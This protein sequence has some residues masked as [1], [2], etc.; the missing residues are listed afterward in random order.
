MTL[1]PNEIATGTELLS[2]QLEKLI[3]DNR[4]VSDFHEAFVYYCS[5]KYSLGSEATSVVTDGKGDVGID[6][7]SAR[8]R[9]Y[10]VGQCKI[11]DQRWL[12]ANPLKT[13]PFGSSVVADPKTALRYLLGE[14]KFN[15]NEKVRH[16]YALVESDRIQEDFSLTFFLIV[17]GRLD[18]RARDAFEEL[19]E[20]YSSRKNI[21][22][23]LQEIDDLVDEFL[24]GAS[25]KTEIQL[26]F[27]IDKSGILSA[28]NYCY[29][30]ANAAD[31]F[32]AFRNYGWRL[33]DLNLRYEIRN[34]PINNDIITTLKY[35]KS[36]KNFHHY[37]NGLTIITK[38]YK[39]RDNNSKIHLTNPQIVNGLQT[40]KSIYNAITLKEVSFEELEK[41]CLIQVKVVNISDTDFITRVVRATNNQNPMSQRN[42]KAN[43]REQ[44]TLRVSCAQL[45]PRWFF[46]VK[47]G[48]W[49]SLTQESGQFFK[50][51]VN[52]PPNEFCVDSNKRRPRLID[53]EDA[54]KAWLAFI[55]FA[56][57]AGER[58][59]HY[60]NNDK[61]Y[62][63][64]FGRRPSKSY[65]Q[66]FAIALDFSESRTQE[67]DDYQGNAEQYLLA[68]FLWQFTKHFIPS[69]QK[70]R[71]EAL[72]EGVNLGKITKSSGSITSSEKT[73]ED[74]LTDSFIYQTWRLMANMKELLVEA[75]AHVLCRKYGPLDG[76]VCRKLLDDFDAKAF[77]TT[78]EIKETV[79]NA[80]SSSYIDPQAVFGRIF[81]L[82]KHTAGQF[83]EDKRISLLSTSRI[84]LTLLRR[85]I[86][87]DFKR[88]IWE[89]NERRHL[90]KP[91]KPEGKTFLESLPKLDG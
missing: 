71:E 56:D 78:G 16:L 37:N 66:K 70:Y 39:S 81:G 83:W 29:F 88:K 11:P 55:G 47:E 1:E 4:E 27:R 59:T 25:N 17:Y 79:Q 85:E 75:A 32:L 12:E 86:A 35:Q 34:S 36:R 26:D 3:A 44:K 5:R 18:A 14:S 51:V 77:L 48:E 87:A 21:R 8:D 28:N 74:F 13:R 19:K 33:F 23:I 15:A 2:K 82:L 22:F 61:V 53:N 52:H 20:Q 41:D 84:R 60:F 45:N 72:Q 30:L 73:Q 57:L 80:T 65:W 54:A 40:V 68:Y 91:W 62:E 64:A 69:P 6:F 58:V 38:S 10:N 49:S 63:L 76:S 89:V 24:V 31:V 50:Q 67:L 46:Q 43:M 42:L 90:D 7:F 9:N